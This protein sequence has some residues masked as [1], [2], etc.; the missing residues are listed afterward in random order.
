M[1]VGWD[2]RPWEGPQGLNQKE[3][4][5][6]TDRT[7]EQFEAFLKDAVKWMNNSTNYTTKERIIL[8]YAWNELGEGGY[9]IP[10]KGDSQ[11]QYLKAVK[12]AVLE[13]D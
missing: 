5:Y 8:L 3:G 11:A 7:P 2:K 1:T 13:N 10:T 9:L 12:N 4:W 6:Y